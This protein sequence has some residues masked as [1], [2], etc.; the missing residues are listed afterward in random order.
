MKKLFLSI[1]LL[2]CCIVFTGC[3]GNSNSYDG[4]YRITIDGRIIDD[5]SN[6]SE[7]A[8]VS[9]ARDVK[10]CLNGVEFPGHSFDT[11]GNYIFTKV[12]FEQEADQVISQ[13]PSVIELF[14]GSSDEA[15]ATIEFERIVPLPQSIIITRTGANK[16]SMTGSNGSIDAYYYNGVEQDGLKRVSDIRLEKTDKLIA[17]V[18]LFNSLGNSV[19][20]DFDYWKITAIKPNGDSVSWTS[21]QNEVDSRLLITPSVNGSVKYY[22]INLSSK[23]EE[24]IGSNTLENTSI[25]INEIKNNGADVLPADVLSKAYLP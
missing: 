2:C 10:L 16:I 19:H 7:R 21:T 12:M 14:E 4:A 17:K 1:L 8:S 24:K 9:G 6:A 11:D 23:G 15:F 5:N 25:R 13:N 22:T 18:T 3:G 20:V